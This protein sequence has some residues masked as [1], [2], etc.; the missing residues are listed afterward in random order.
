MHIGKAPH[1]YVRLT[2]GSKVDLAWWKCFLQSWNGSSFFPLPY[3]SAH[4]YSDAS[5]SFGCG[6]VVA[7]TSSLTDIST[8]A[9][10][11]GHWY[12]LLPCGRHWAGKHIRFHCDNLAV[13]MILSTRMAKTPPLMHLLR[14]FSFYCAHFCFHFSTQHVP[15]IMNTAEDA[16]SRDVLFPCPPD[17]QVHHLPPCAT[18]PSSPT[19]PLSATFRLLVKCQT[20][21]CLHLPNS[22]MF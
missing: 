14:C 1:H 9:H 22:T 8:S 6:A 15:G 7:G 2:A 10:S 20:Q 13:V 12:W 5:G 16:I 11:A 21:H 17:T 19:C 18:S 4:V 3:P